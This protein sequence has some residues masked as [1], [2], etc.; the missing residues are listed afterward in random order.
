MTDL[1]IAQ[2]Y[3]DLLIKQYAGK[4]RAYATIEALTQEAV[5][6][7]LPVAVQNAYDLNTAEGVQLDVIGKY[8]GITRYGTDFSGPISLSDS[9]FRQLIKFAIIR[10]NGG[11]SLY[12]I[13][14]LISV[15]FPGDFLVFDFKNMQM[16][17]F[18]STAIGSAQ[19][20][21][22]ILI[23]GLLPKPMGVGIGSVIYAPYVNQF[24]GM[25]SYQV[26]AFPAWDP[27][28]TYAIGQVVQYGGEYYQNILAGNFDNVPVDGP[29]WK[30]FSGYN[31]NGFNTYG[32]YNTTWT[33]LNYTYA[34]VV[35]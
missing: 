32:N 14:K 28:V 9:D 5:V 8:V 12:D 17:Y 20:A 34:I 31:V 30:Y 15:F 6:N 10:N 23:Q 21:E 27:A 24:F 11:S 19:L 22:M 29:Y 25:I 33:W 7:Q 16:S 2:Y 18:F 13:Q 35:P 1:E 26:T 4:P 3:A